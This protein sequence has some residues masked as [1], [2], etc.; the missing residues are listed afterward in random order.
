MHDKEIARKAHLNDD[1]QLEIQPRLIFGHLRCALGFI[2][3]KLQH[4]LLQA[5]IGKQ[6]Q[7]I[8]ERHAVG[9]GKLRQKVFAQRD[10]DIAALGDFH[11][12]LQRFGQIG[13]ALGHHLGRH[14]KLAR[15]KFVRALFIRQHPAAGNAHP[16]FVRFEIIGVGKLR[17]MRGHHGQIERGGNL[18]AAGHRSFPLRPLGQPL[19]FQVKRIGKPSRVFLRGGLGGFFVAVEQIGAH[20]AIMRAREA[21]QAAVVALGQPALAQLGMVDIAVFAHI[22]GGEQFA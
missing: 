4:A 12:I 8:I 19:Q 7:I 10:V 2:G 9:R 5:L 18:Q 11:R 21:D 13:K 1:F 17:R 6:A 14:E 15:R 3:V 16:R 22:S 20:F